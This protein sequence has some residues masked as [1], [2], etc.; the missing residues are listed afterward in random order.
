MTVFGWAADWHACSKE[1]CRQDLVHAG[2]E[3]ANLWAGRCIHGPAGLLGRLQLEGDR[4]GHELEARESGHGV[5]QGLVGVM[6]D[7]ESF[8]RLAGLSKVSADVA[9]VAR[10]LAD[11]LVD[12]ARA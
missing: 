6:S 9:D 7:D 11:D 1:P 3:L 12:A 5:T 10:H 4:V 8:H 2:I